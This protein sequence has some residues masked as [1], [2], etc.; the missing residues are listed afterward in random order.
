MSAESAD[1]VGGGRHIATLRVASRSLH[2]QNLQRL[3]YAV[4]DKICRAVAVRGPAGSERNF[5]PG[6]SLC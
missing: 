1:R 4:R 5:R 3:S 6:V 2:S